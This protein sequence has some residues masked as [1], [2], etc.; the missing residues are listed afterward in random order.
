[1]IMG[2]RNPGN[3]KGLEVSSKDLKALL[4]H[5]QLPITLGV[6]RDVVIL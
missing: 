6:V 5:D 4:H 1:V 2:Y 3:K